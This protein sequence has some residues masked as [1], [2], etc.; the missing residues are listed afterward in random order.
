MKHIQTKFSGGSTNE[1]FTQ[2]QN[3]MW[4]NGNK[5]SKVPGIIDDGKRSNTRTPNSLGS[6]KQ[7]LQKHLEE[8]DKLKRESY[9]TMMRSHRKLKRGV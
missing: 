6:S 3:R 1:N 9:V 5:T 4:N 7:E 2:T 8:A